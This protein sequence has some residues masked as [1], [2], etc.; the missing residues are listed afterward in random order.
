MTDE[1]LMIRTDFYTA[2]M[3]L[4]TFAAIGFMIATV[5]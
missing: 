2:L 1:D 4:V 3:A 5:I